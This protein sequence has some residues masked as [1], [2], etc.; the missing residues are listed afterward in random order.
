LRNVF[1][2]EPVLLSRLGKPA[3]KICWDMHVICAK[4][5][6]K[7][8]PTGVGKFTVVHKHVYDFVR[9]QDVNL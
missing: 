9:I 6:E 1:E 7:I 8:L 4:Q 5:E 3:Q 2:Q